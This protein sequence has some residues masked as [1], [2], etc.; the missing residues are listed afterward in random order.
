MDREVSSL[1][2]LSRSG[3]ENA[4]VDLAA[5]Y[6]PLIE[7]M[8]KNYAAKC[9]SILYTSDDFVQEANLAFYSAVM[10]YDPDSAVGFG[11]YAKICIRNR[12]VSLLR[13]SAKKSK[14]NSDDGEKKNGYTEPVYGFLE[15]EDTEQIEKKVEG[16]LSKFEWSVFLL[17]LQNKTYR[18]IAESLGK[19]EKAVD[20]A[21]VRAKRKL[22][23]LREEK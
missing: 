6:K 11:Y 14:K 16:V 12:L 10:S 19:T 2:A 23:T 17:Y 3:D 22:K 4:F 8:G 18:E 1:I 9:G 13:S 5:K 7:S 21:L 20:N 15:R